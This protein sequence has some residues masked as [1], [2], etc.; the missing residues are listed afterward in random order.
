MLSVSLLHRFCV[1]SLFTLFLHSYF[2]QV[3]LLHWFI[4]Y[5]LTQMKTSFLLL[6]LRP[7][8]FMC[9]EELHAVLHLVLQAGNLLNA[10]SRKK[11]TLYSINE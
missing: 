2:Q 8:E 4:L 3:M 9:C 10:V 1:F 5:V 6:C 11:K 7:P